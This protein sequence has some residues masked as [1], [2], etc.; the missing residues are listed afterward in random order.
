[1]HLTSAQ[2]VKRSCAFDLHKHLRGHSCTAS[3]HSTWHSCCMHGTAC[4]VALPGFNSAPMLKA[5]KAAPAAS[6]VCRYFGNQRSMLIPN[7]LFRV[8]GAA[9]VLSNKLKD[10]WRAK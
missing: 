6:G 4:A 5:A 10:S 3:S 1:M 9:V 2:P 8:G 7:C